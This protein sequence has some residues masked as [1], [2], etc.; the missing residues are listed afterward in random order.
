[1]AEKRGL[2]HGI[3]GNREAGKFSV[4]GF[5]N[6]VLP[7]LVSCG[8]NAVGGAAAMILGEKIDHWKAGWGT[9]STALIAI[10]VKAA[11]QPVS[12]GAV[13]V[14]ELAAG[15]A[16]YVGDE[17]VEGLL[18]MWKS[19]KWVAGKVW[20]TG[21]L[22][23]HDG[24]YYEASEDLAADGG[25]PGEDK[26]WVAHTS[27]KFGVS[28]IK[29]CAK[30]VFQDK[31]RVETISSFLASQLGTARGWTEQE[32]AGAKSDLTGAMNKVAEEIATL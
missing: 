28:D 23:A 1:M 18:L 4:N 2:F 8:L 16:G 9:M 27:A 5:A 10:A 21:A 7:A 20:K 12:D 19:T 17:V 24:K 6:N 31:Q 26:R 3:G 13:A 32:I 29:E 25:K 15:M 14:R 11:V 22:V 30:L